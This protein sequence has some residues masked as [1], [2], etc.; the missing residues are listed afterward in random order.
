[1]ASESGATANSLH[2]LSFCCLVSGAL[3]CFDDS[4][5]VFGAA[6]RFAPSSSKSP[7]E[8]DGCGPTRF[9]L[10]QLSSSFLLAAPFVLLVDSAAVFVVVV[11]LVA[12]V[13]LAP[14]VSVPSLSDEPK[15]ATRVLT[16]AISKVGS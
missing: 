11:D 5:P 1:M 2:T 9:V 15:S 8:A 7:H 4:S 16:P 14:A 3:S 6:R 13:R 12:L 10:A